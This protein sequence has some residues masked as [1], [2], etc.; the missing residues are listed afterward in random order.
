MGWR[1]GWRSG[2][3]LLLTPWVLLAGASTARAGYWGE[4]FEIHGEFSSRAFF[5]SPSLNFGQEFQMSSW[6]NELELDLLLRLREQGD[7]R[8][9]LSARLN[10]SYDAVYDVYSVWG[11]QPRGGAFGTGRSED[12]KR[13]I[14]AFLS[15]PLFSGDQPRNVDCV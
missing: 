3:V 13:G 12:Q 8:A 1:S 4:N 10:P 9:D 15:R 14:R 7:F 2:G 5:R 6:H 11:R